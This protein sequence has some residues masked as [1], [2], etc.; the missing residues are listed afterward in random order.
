MNYRIK[1][2][3][4]RSF[5]VT[6]LLVLLQSTEKFYKFQ[7]VLDEQEYE[8]YIKLINKLDIDPEIT[9]ICVVNI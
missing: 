4:L 7:L 6:V 1:W 5:L 2:N 8:D 3:G 9:M